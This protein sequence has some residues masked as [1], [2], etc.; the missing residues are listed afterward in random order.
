LV[1]QSLL[2]ENVCVTDLQLDPGS[3]ADLQGELRY[4]LIAVLHA[5]TSK[6]VSSGSES[7]SATVSSSPFV[8]TT[9]GRTTGMADAQG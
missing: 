1:E 8:R 4:L 9:A 2:V 5:A 6:A 3:V 7:V